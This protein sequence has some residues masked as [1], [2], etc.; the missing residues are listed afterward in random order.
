MLAGWQAEREKVSVGLAER[1]ELEA[2]VAGLASTLEGRMKGLVAQ[3]EEQKAECA[4]LVGERTELDGAFAQV[5]ALGLLFCSR[6]FLV[7]I[8]APLCMHQPVSFSK[9]RG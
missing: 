9:M 7:A 3:L 1:G 6:Y 5:C 4:R 2:S 8:C